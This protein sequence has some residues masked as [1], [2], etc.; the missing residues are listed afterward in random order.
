MTIK[1]WAPHQLKFQCTICDKFLVMFFNGDEDARILQIDLIF[2]L[3]K[4]FFIPEFYESLQ[5]YDCS[6]KI[7]YQVYFYI[8]AR[9]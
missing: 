2:F 6:M 1:S 8:N 4:S 3:L 7:N 9:F 5:I